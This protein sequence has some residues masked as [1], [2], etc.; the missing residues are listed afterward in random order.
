MVV[1][2]MGEWNKILNKEILLAI[3][4]KMLLQSILVAS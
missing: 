3:R 1:V 4:F 2:V